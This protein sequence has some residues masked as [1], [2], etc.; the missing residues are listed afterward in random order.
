[1]ELQSPLDGL[2]DSASRWLG[3]LGHSPFLVGDT[4]QAGPELLTLT[5]VRAT[6]R[7]AVANVKTNTLLVASGHTTDGGGTSMSAPSGPSN[8]NVA[9]GWRDTVV[10]IQRGASQAVE[11]TVMLADTFTVKLSG[12][13]PCFIFWQVTN[14]PKLVADCCRA[15]WGP[16]AAVQGQR[17]STHSHH[18]P[19]QQDVGCST[20]STVQFCMQV[21]QVCSCN[22]RLPVRVRAMHVQ[23]VTWLLCCGGVEPCT[24]GLWPCLDWCWVAGEPAATDTQ[25]ATTQPNPVQLEGVPGVRLVVHLMLG[26][27]STV[28]CSLVKLAP[29]LPASKDTVRLLLDALGHTLS[30]RDPLTL[31]KDKPHSA[32]SIRNMVHVAHMCFAVK[33][34]PS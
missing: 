32:H 22:M 6:G 13:G 4:V 14:T 23:V 16:A 30:V 25:L 33:L 18:R 11:G 26:A 29:A 1:M 34:G 27:S 19:A 9:G 10:T 2:A 20:L 7:G 21:V 8:T 24:L 3:E 31:A 28:A 5:V 15:V 12:H 17:S